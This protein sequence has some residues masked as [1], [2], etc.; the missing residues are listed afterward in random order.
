MK[1]ILF[2]TGPFSL[3][4]CGWR[5]ASWSVHFFVCQTLSSLSQFGIS[6]QH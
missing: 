1:D 4:H 5:G 2:F 6:G 3:A